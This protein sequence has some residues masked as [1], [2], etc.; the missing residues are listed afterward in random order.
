MQLYGESWMLDK[1]QNY[2][3]RQA[4]S[5]VLMFTVVGGFIGIGGMVFWVTYTATRWV[6]G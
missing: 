5:V 1:L 4:V 6:I 2:W 3:V